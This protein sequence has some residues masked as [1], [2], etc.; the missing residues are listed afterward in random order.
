[1]TASLSAL[2]D[3]KVD[4][5]LDSAPRALNRPDLFPNLDA[6]AVQTVD[7][8]PRG[9]PPMEGH[10]GH[11]FV[12]AHTDL[13][14]LNE[15]SDEVD[16]ERSVRGTPDCSN[17]RAND[18]GRKRPRSKRPDGPGLTHC[19]GEVWRGANKSHASQRDRILDPVILCESCF[20]LAHDAIM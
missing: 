15:E 4:P 7:D 17:Q 16:V 10:D 6:S 14:L 9:M 8:K 18:F 19:D 1:V 12:N 3:D 5:V 2:R 11:R 20:N 13:F